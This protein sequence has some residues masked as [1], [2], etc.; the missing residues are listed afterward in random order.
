MNNRRALALANFILAS[1]LGLS[2]VLLAYAGYRSDSYP[3][4]TMNGYYIVLAAGILLCASALRWREAQKEVAALSLLSVA[5]GGYLIET[6]LF[7]C[8]APVDPTGLRGEAA[9]SANVP[10]DTR[11]RYQVFRDLREE[12][13]EVYPSVNAAQLAGRAALEPEGKALLPLAGVSGT[14][15][16]LCNESGEYAFYQA[17]EHGFNNPPGLYAQSDMVLLGD[18]FAHG[19]CVSAGE[20]IAGQLRARQKN[21]VNLGYSGDGPLMELATL[22]EYAAPLG[23]RIVLWL[24]YEGNDLEDLLVEE[25]KPTLKAYLDP[26]FTQHLLQRQQEIDSALADYVE[27]KAEETE[28]TDA[29]WLDTPLARIARLQHSRDRLRILLHSFQPAPAPPPLFGEVLRAARDLTAAG[30][31]RLYMVYLPSWRR[32]ATEANAGELYH[33][34]QVLAI[35]RGLDIPVIDIHQVFV[36]HPDPL[37]LFP[38]G[39]EGHYTAEG[40]GLVAATIASNL[41]ELGSSP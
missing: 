2:A 1:G 26:D 13:R 40:Y 4:G 30:G 38:F 37:A 7:C 34:D 36:R 11:T 6:F 33:R 14:L 39:L 41:G 29:G 18:S 9:R 12:G 24:Y 15:T 21:A 16:I 31:G 22:K 20:D 27:R 5:I 35:A 17:D 23:P 19:N 10:F 8:V 32:Y 25:R 3:P 28:G